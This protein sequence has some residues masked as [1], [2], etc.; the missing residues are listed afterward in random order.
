MIYALSTWQERDALSGDTLRAEDIGKPLASTIAG[1]HRHAILILDAYSIIRFATTR[2]LFGHSDEELP[3]TPLKSL[4]PTLPMRPSTPGYNV[5]YARL[6]FADQIWQSHRAVSRER[7][8]FPVELCVR[9]LP[10]GRSFTL[11]AAVREVR[12]VNSINAIAP[13]RIPLRFDR[14]EEG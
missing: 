2:R 8:T 3:E 6:A 5:A 1:H 11:L 14:A 13:R 4:I 12:P 9:T 7:R 10:M